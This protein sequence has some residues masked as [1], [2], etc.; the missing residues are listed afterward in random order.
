MRTP[1]LLIVDKKMPEM[2]GLTCLQEIKNAGYILP[3]VLASGS[4]SELDE[5]L[6]NNLISKII[7]K[8]YNFEEL[9]CLVKELIG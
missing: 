5:P 9:L 8:P 4:P 2:D 7:N 1:D 6:P 3:I